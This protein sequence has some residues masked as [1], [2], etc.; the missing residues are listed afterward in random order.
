MPS[1]KD[2]DKSKMFQKIM[3]SSA[4]AQAADAA[5]NETLENTQEAPTPQDASSS[6]SGGG[7]LNPDQ[8]AAL[9]ATQQTDDAPEAAAPAEAPAPEEPLAI[10]E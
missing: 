10:K 8:I 2:L 4:A 5:K 6:A 3:P 1:K 7:T 9:F